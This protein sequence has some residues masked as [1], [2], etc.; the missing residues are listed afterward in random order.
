MFRGLVFVVLIA[1]CSNAKDK[2]PPAADAGQGDRPATETGPAESP[3]AEAGAAEVDPM[4]MCDPAREVL[5]HLAGMTPNGQVRY[6]M[7]RCSRNVCAGG[8]DIGAV[9]FA[10]TYAG[11]TDAAKG[12]DIAYTRT[13]H[14]WNDSLVA[15]LPDRVLKWRIV[16]D[17][18][19]PV[20]PPKQFVSV[21]TLAGDPILADTEVIAGR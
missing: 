7:D 15:T 4:L 8:C 6:V 11:R 16:V 20:F 9:S 21:E 17:E 5:S 1:A 18:L 13:H 12:S 19:A 10:L 2:P 3:V 14:N